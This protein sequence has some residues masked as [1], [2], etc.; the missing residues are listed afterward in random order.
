M[1]TRC[2]H[3]Y[4]KNKYTIYIAHI[5][6]HHALHRQFSLHYDLTDFIMFPDAF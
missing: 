1:D 6:I 2:R 5:N 4:N 3:V